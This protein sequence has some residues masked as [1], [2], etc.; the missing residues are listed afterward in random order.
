M[1][2][3]C[4]MP[5]TRPASLTPNCVN[6]TWARS[7]IPRSCD[8][9]MTCGVIYTS[10]RNCWIDMDCSDA[11]GSPGFTLCPAHQRWRGLPES[12]EVTPKCPPM[13]GYTLSVD[14]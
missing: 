2:R 11:L 13:Y 4:E 12:T 5:T 9:D 1:G 14:A 3:S 6:S 7:G 10:R 8:N